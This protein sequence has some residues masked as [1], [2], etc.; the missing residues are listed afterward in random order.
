MS[1][2]QA[3]K[4]KEKAEQE[5]AEQV[6][7]PSYN[8]QIQEEEWAKEDEVIAPKKKPLFSGFK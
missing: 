4:L 6:T 5:K 3:K 2:R 7:L 8:F 1:L